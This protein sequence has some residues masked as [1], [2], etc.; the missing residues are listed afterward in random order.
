[1]ESHCAQN[2]EFS[3]TVIEQNTSAY[4]N[5]GFKCDFLLS[6]EYT[7]NAALTASTKSKTIDN[8]L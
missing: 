8:A 6:K 2:D 4:V 5:T 7:S 3:T 1:M